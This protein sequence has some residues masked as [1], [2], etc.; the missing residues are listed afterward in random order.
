MTARVVTSLE[1]VTLGSNLRG[2]IVVSRWLHAGS[3]PRIVVPA[4]WADNEYAS[5]AMSIVSELVRLYEVWVLAER[6][7]ELGSMRSSVDA[8]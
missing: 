4:A 7:T 8:H 2:G 5:H 1:R 6:Q 3:V